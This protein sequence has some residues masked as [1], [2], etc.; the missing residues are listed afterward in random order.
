MTNWYHCAPAITS[1]N[2]GSLTVWQNGEL[3]CSVEKVQVPGT[4]CD[5]VV[6][7]SIAT[8]IEFGPY[9][10]GQHHLMI[11]Y[12]GSANYNYPT[13]D[14]CGANIFGDEAVRSA[15]PRGAMYVR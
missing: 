1:P 6:P 7:V 10:Y 8:S 12:D 3:N 9:L 5:E 14:P 11:L 13:H 4:G 2:P 15:D